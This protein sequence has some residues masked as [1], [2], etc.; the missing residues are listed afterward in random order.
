MAIGDY[1]KLNCHML[2]MAI[3]VAIL[4]MDIGWY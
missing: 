3:D 1:F 4:L 2:L